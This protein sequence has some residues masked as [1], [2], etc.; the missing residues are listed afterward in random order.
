MHR[1][2]HPAMFDHPKQSL[3]R[4]QKGSWPMEIGRR[5]CEQEGVRS[6]PVPLCAMTGRAMAFVDRFPTGHVG[7]IVL[8]PQRDG[9]GRHDGKNEADTYAMADRGFSVHSELL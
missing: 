1:A 8:R 5:D 4:F 6:V 7:R 3:I 9:G 2:E